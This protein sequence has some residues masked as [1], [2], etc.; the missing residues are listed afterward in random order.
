MVLNY[1]DTDRRHQKLKEFAQSRG[2]SVAKLIAEMVET[3]GN[4]IKGGLGDKSKARSIMFDD[5][6]LQK[7][8]NFSKKAGMSKSSII[9]RIIDLI[10]ANE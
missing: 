2:L 7:L 10:E 6:S 5:T 3:E 1:R 9:R 8:N 4:R